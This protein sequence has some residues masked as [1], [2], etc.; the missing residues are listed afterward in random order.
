MLAGG[1][2]R[3]VGPKV[4]VSV[5]SLAFAERIRSYLAEMSVRQDL[6][7]PMPLNRFDYKRNR[8]RLEPGTMF[9]M[10]LTTGPETANHLVGPTVCK[11]EPR[12]QNCPATSALKVDAQFPLKP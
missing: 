12:P 4:P 11:T 1:V 7:P 2:R 9:T 10:G 8:L 3:F 5:Q 6:F